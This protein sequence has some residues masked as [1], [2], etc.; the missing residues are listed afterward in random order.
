VT[1][2][3]YPPALAIWCWFAVN[4]ILLLITLLPFKTVKQAPYFT[5]LLNTYLT[6]LACLGISSVPGATHCIADGYC[7]FYSVQIL[8][9]Q[10]IMPL[11][12][13]FLFYVY[14]FKKPNIYFL[15]LSLGGLGFWIIVK[16]A[17]LEVIDGMWGMG[18]VILIISGLAGFA[19]VKIHN[20]IK[21]AEND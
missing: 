16:F 14:F 5:Y 19:L 2:A 6:V 8:L 1:L 12:A 18:L 17:R 20:K 13:A 15:G 10:N 7:P 11:W 4:F 9:S 3:F 21:G